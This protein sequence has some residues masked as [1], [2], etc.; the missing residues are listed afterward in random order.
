MLAHKFLD[1]SFLPNTCPEVQQDGYLATK[2]VNQTSF[3]VVFN[4]EK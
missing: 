4:I 2:E 3:E 1:L